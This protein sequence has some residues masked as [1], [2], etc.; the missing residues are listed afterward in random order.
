MTG[1][2]I[3]LSPG[4]QPEGSAESILTRA[5]GPGLS[6]RWRRGDT[7]PIT[8]KRFWYYNKRGE[9]WLSSA[10]YDAYLSRTKAR[11][12]Q[13][14]SENRDKANKAAASWAR[15]F[16]E[17]R[18]KAAA[19]R[20]RRDRERILAVGRAYYRKSDKK[21]RREKCYAWRNKNYERFSATH[22]HWVKANAARVREYRKKAKQNRY[23]D[24][25]AENGHRVQKAKSATANKRF[26]RE[27]YATARRLSQCTGIPFHVDHIRPIARGGKHEESNL[28]VMSG[29]LNLRKGASE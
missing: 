4:L 1:S 17:R 5:V 9:L 23:L 13:Y 22:L 7:H 21:A 25:L 26:I 14:R 19:E 8:G 12:A 18:A 27:F 15:R 29:K 2:D 24:C 6:K 20:Y 11:S 28:Q 10:T 3:N 16:P